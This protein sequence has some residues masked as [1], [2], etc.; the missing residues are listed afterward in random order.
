MKISVFTDKNREEEIVIFAHEE[1][2]LINQIK[3]LINDYSSQI[4]GFKE[5]EI[6]QLKA[7]DIYC[8][9]VENNKVFAITENDKFLLKNRLY[10][11][12]EGLSS[13]FIKINKSCIAN[14]K[15]I[16]R[17]D[18]AITGTLMVRFKNGYTDYVSRRSVK[19]V[20]ERL[21]L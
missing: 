7:T 11:I 9:T 16:E 1:T 17:F 8:F 19:T 14:I 4:T 6:Y 3:S 15:K 5:N 13:D 20:K 21:G 12:E 10:S 18:A 2:E